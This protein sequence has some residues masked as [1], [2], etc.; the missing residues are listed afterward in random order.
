[1]ESN[2]LNEL[3]AQ[4]RSA[5]GLVQ[6]LYADLTGEEFDVES[7]V[8]HYPLVALGLAAGVGVAAGWWLGRKGRPELPAPP[9]EPTRPAQRALEYVEEVLPGAVERA[10]AHL[11]EIVLSDAARARA[12]TWLGNILERELQQGIDRWADGADAR[13]GS[14]FR[15]ATERLD[16]E[17]EVRLDDPEPPE[18]TL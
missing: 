1:M 9:P 16:P 7:A 12:K 5:T 2:D 13:L 10:R 18:Q 17:P 4:M 11:P 8:R 6:T 14:L 15:R 3:L